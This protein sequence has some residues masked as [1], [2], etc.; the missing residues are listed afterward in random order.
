MITVR[1][2]S[3]NLFYFS[4]VNLVQFKKYYEEIIFVWFQCQ[5]FL[6]TLL[7]GFLH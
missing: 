1:S 7:Q 2:Y 3:K 5:K 6:Y 4:S